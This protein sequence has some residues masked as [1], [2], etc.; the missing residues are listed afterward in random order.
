MRSEEVGVAH[1]P[2]YPLSETLTH[3][4]QRN[5]TVSLL[6]SSLPSCFFFH[7]QLPL[8]LNPCF[9]IISC[10]SILFFL[11][12]FPPLFQ[13]ELPTIAKWIPPTLSCFAFFFLTCVDSNLSLILGVNCKSQN[14]YLVRLLCTP[15][16]HKLSRSWCSNLLLLF[17]SFHHRTFAKVEKSWIVKET[18][19]SCPP[20]TVNDVWTVH[21]SFW[22]GW[23]REGH[24]HE[25]GHGCKCVCLCLCH[26]LSA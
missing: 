6:S 14:C 8:T 21:S 19:V 17:T 22:G 10:F 18:R 15:L 23:E 5:W 4:G 24:P 13:E 2:S 26:F 11:L 7:S 12:F 16:R 25:W 20:L 9:S 1:P 3:A